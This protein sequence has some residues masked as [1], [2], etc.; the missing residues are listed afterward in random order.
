MMADK[1]TMVASGVINVR[2]VVA[3]LKNHEKCA[4]T[5]KRAGTQTIFW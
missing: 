4:Y 2:T 3:I 1:S 5:S